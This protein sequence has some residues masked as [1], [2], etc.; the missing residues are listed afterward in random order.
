[1][2]GK[3]ISWI[4]RQIVRNG[5]GSNEPPLFNTNRPSLVLCIPFLDNS[6]GLLFFYLH[7]FHNLFLLI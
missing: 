1:M 7:V 2:I 6:P 3:Q 4:R 5:A